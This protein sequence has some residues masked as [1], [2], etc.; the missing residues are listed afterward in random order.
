MPW[1]QAPALTPVTLPLLGY[2][3]VALHSHTP[4]LEAA[5]PQVPLAKVRKPAR[6]LRFD[7]NPRGWGYSDCSITPINKIGA[8]FINS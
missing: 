2:P 6:A 7:P 1:D 8:F 4:A 3:V 5:A